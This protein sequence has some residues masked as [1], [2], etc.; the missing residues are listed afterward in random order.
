M[1][2]GCLGWLEDLRLSGVGGTIEP[3]SGRGGIA[4]TPLSILSLTNINIFGTLA[5]RSIQLA[6]CLVR[7]QL[8]SNT[9]TRCSWL[10]LGSI[11]CV[12]VAIIIRIYL[13]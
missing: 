2:D 11:I 12:N 9:H 13:N 8:F 6:M 4:R 5:I 3:G 1:I 7:V 10:L